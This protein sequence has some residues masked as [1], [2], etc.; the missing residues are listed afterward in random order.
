MSILNL[1]KAFQPD[2]AKVEGKWPHKLYFPKQVLSCDDRC[3]KQVLSCIDRCPKQVLSCDDRC[4]KQ[5]L[6]GDEKCLF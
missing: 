2:P 4:P 1:N 5:V 6:S 3:P